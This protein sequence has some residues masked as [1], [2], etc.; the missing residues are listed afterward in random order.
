MQG[1]LKMSTS[2]E[3][4]NAVTVVYRIEVRDLKFV[5]NTMRKFTD[6]SESRYALGD[7]AIDVTAQGFTFVAT[8]GKVMCVLQR[9]YAAA[10][11]LGTK[12]ETAFRS[13]VPL[14]LSKLAKV[15]KPES[16][17]GSVE[18]LVTLVDGVVRGVMFI[19]AGKDNREGL[20]CLAVEGRFPNWRDV[21][22][23]VQEYGDSRRVNA[24]EFVNAY[25]NAVTAMA[26]VIFSD[27]GCCLIK[28]ES[29]LLK[30]VSEEHKSLKLDFGRLLKIFR[31]AKGNLYLSLHRAYGPLRIQDTKAS[32][33]YYLVQATQ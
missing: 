25:D 21:T 20:D 33:R 32:C 29:L 16:K 22:P 15:F 2:V 11:R 23:P 5:L 14:D 31:A 4:L 8:D 7:V 9:D 3:V 26:E 27:I 1:D 30:N 18:M 17:C 28:P 6:S 13:C 19:W 24:A 10:D 12:V